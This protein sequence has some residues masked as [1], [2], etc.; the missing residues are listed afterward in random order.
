MYKR[1]INS[2][3]SKVINT[4]GF[5]TILASI[6]MGLGAISLSDANILSEQWKKS[7]ALSPK[8][9]IVVICLDMV[10]QDFAK[11][12][13]EDNQQA[14][15]LFDGFIFFTNTASASPYT[16]LSMG[17]LIRGGVFEGKSREY[18]PDN[19]INDMVGYGYDISGSEKFFGPQE[20]TGTTIPNTGI[21]SAVDETKALLL[22]GLNRYYPF[23]LREAEKAEFGN[24]SKTDQRESYEMLIS[25]LHI[26]K[27]ISKRML[28][29]HTLQTHSPVRFTKDGVFSFD[30]TPDDVQGEISD[31]LTM[32]GRL[33]E[34][35]KNLNIYDD[36]LILIISDHGF[37]YLNQMKT[38]NHEQQYLLHQISTQTPNKRLV[39]QYQP[40]MMIKPPNSYGVLKY[41]NSAVSLLDIRYT[42]NK[43]ISHG[44]LQNISGINI[45]NYD[46]NPEERITPVFVF[47][48]DKFESK[49]F[50]STENWQVR[51]LKMPFQ[52][53]YGNPS[54]SAQ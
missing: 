52:K 21:L 3:Y 19:L 49:D 34:K 44:A 1:K 51:E 36:T 50:F 6:Y 23:K 30:L 38:L 14:K 24:I 31:A 26:D 9:N 48:G 28:W 15:I 18:P 46:Q 53:Y 41:N 11:S 54:N 2:L 29:F 33:L 27:N 37:V 16:S 32:T 8:G 17:S 45:L 43:F 13:F 20:H 40:L 22:L 12:Y 4:L 42:L 47:M 25:S 39:G 7:T 35:L 5:F 10:Q